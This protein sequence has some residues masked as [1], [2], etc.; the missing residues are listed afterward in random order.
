M[1]TAMSSTT[2]FKWIF[3]LNDVRNY[4]NY[5][6]SVYLRVKLNAI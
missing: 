4:I 1:M 6:P 3:V 2:L 5:S